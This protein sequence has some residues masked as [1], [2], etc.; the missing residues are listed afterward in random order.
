[1]YA[2]RCCGGVSLD[3]VDCANINDKEVGV[4]RTWWHPFISW[5]AQFVWALFQIHIYTICYCSATCRMVSF[6][7]KN[8]GQL[9]RTTV[10]VGLEQSENSSQT[11][12]EVVIFVGKETFL[13]KS[14]VFSLCF[15]F[16][17][18]YHMYKYMNNF[19]W[20]TAEFG[21]CC[22]QVII[23]CALHLLPKS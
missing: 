20:Y 19:M 22:C 15:C 8:N 9:Q 18:L 23:V 16:A 3:V 14:H 5:Q 7:D 6:S 17:N 21:I 10:S 4:W 11:I 12:S 13:F 1:M 2:V